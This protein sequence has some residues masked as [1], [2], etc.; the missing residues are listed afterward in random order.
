MYVIEGF[1]HADDAMHAPSVTKT[2]FASHTW[3][4]LLSTDVFGS[5]PIR[6]VPISWMVSPGGGLVVVRRRRSC[7]RPLRASRRRRGL[8]IL[9]DGPLVVAPLHVDPQHRNAPL[10]DHLRVDGDP[11][12][13]MRQ[14]LAEA[15]EAH[16]PRPILRHLE[17]ALEVGA[18]ALGRH[19]A[20]ATPQTAGSHH[21]GRHSRAGSRDALG[22]VA[23]AREVD[24]VGPAPEGP[25]V[26]EA[27]HVAAGAGLHRVVHQVATEDVAVAA[28]AVRMG[29]ALRVEEDAGG[30]ERRGADED[31]PRR[32]TRAPP[33]SGASITRTP[34][35]FPLA[36]SQA[37]D[38][39]TEKGR[40]RQRPVASAST[41]VVCTE[42]KYDAVV[43]PR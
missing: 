10:V 39:T 28:E 12:V 8:R 16:P 31:D 19:A 13:R 6:A 15:A 43:Q 17:R 22:H 1:W 27:R 21:P 20:A 24:A 37:T 23:E 34:V 14:A 7:S 36:S 9:H 42:L 29:A 2:F 33:S 5:F 18:E 11:V 32:G 3:F 26:L 30:L 40:M 4:H 38:C 25:L 41:S 35:T